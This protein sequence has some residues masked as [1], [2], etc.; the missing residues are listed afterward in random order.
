[1]ST[2]YSPS[3]D[4]YVTVHL[5]ISKTYSKTFI[6]AVPI[7]DIKKNTDNTDHFSGPKSSESCLYNGPGVIVFTVNSELVM[8]HCGHKPAT[9]A[10]AML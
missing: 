2:I 3:E 8:S 5:S 1:V 4:E 7:V 10:T 9:F 6:S